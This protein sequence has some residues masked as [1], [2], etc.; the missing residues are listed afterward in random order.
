MET[1]K[2]PPNI[3]YGYL[4]KGAIEIRTFWMMKYGH[5]VMNPNQKHNTLTDGNTLS[6][7]GRIC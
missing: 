4:Q 5:L 2:L 6:T 7:K 1:D 3:L